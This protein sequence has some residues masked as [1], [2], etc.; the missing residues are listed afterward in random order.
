[1]RALEREE[2]Q[3]QKVFSHPSPIPTSHPSFAI[4][5]GAKTQKFTKYKIVIKEFSA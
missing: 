3:V 1:M 4:T 5:N 2:K